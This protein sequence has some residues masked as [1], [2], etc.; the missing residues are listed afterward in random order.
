MVTKERKTATFEPYYWEAY[1]EIV[2]PD[3][4]YWYFIRRW[5]PA[6]SGNAVKIIMAFRGQLYFNPRSGELRNTIDDLDLRH[7]AELTGLSVKTLTRE[8]KKM[9]DPDDPEGRHL[10]A[11]ISKTP[12]WAQVGQNRFRQRPNTYY[13]AMDDPIHPDDQGWYEALREQKERE[14][15]GREEAHPRRKRVVKDAPFLDGH[16][17]HQEEGTVGQVDHQEGQFVSRSG[18]SDHHTNKVFSLPLSTKTT[19]PL[20][21]SNP[22]EGEGERTPPRSIDRPENQRGLALVRETL[23]RKQ[24]GIVPEGHA[25]ER[26]DVRAEIAA[27]LGAPDGPTTPAIEGADHGRGAGPPA[28]LRESP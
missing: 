25:R 23:K 27:S 10:K 18:Q 16:C 11:F 28:P 21:P 19:A 20:P 22:P 6:L 24:G 8:F 12:T 17:D 3:Q 1:N 7:L 2:H 5:L 13:V 26:A 15:I 9:A 14:R 4:R